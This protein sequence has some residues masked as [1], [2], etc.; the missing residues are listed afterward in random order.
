MREVSRPL[1]IPRRPLIASMLSCDLE[2]SWF[3]IAKASLISST[4]PALTSAPAPFA[5]TRQELQAPGGMGSDELFQKQPAEQPREHAHRQEEARPAGYRPLAVQGNA[6][7]R[8]DHV[9]MRMVGERRSPGVHGGHAD[10]RAQV[11]GIGRDRDH[12]L[13]GGHSQPPPAVPPI[14]GQLSRNFYIWPRGT[15]GTRLPA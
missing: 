5:M 11:F 4:R 9:D 2:R 12:R 14:S 6:A 13:G 15:F 8:N 7:T 3:R 10:P 1:F